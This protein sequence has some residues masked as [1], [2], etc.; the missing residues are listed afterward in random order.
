MV[1]YTALRYMQRKQY[2]QTDGRKPRMQFLKSQS[3]ERPLPRPPAP[4]ADQSPDL[5]TGGT[6]PWPSGYQDEQGA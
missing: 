2:H 1:V 5:V 4:L 3:N 6:R